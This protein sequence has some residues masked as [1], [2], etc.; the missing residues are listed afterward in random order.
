MST[1]DEVKSPTDPEQEKRRLEIE[2]LRWKVGRLYRTV[3]SISIFTTVLAVAAFVVS[4]Y[5]ISNESAN[6]R[7]AEA[8]ARGA[9]AAAR[10]REYRKPV[11]ERQLAVLFEVSDSAAKIAT[12]PPDDP[13]RKRA[14]ARFR[15]LYWGQVVLA[16]N[17][18]LKE[19]LV[20]FKNCLDGISDDCASEETKSDRLRD[21]SIFLTNK[22]RAAIATTWE[23]SLAD[24]YER[25]AEEVSSAPTPLP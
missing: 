2:E 19:Q 10:E 4:L 11:W 3:Q 5:Q 21:L 8:S 1:S 24:L 16:E 18:E 6:A 14:E 12:S 22:C 20:K 7:R 23:V 25:K 9:E 13:E 15:Q 17:E